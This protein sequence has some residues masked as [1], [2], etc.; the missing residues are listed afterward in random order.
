MNTPTLRAAIYARYSTDKQTESSI[1]DQIRVCTEWADREGLRTGEVFR[2]E[3]I[4]GAAIGNR[5]GYLTMMDAAKAGRFDALLVMDLSRLSR[6]QGDLPK[7]IERL[8]HSGVRVVGVQDGFDSARKGHKLQAGFSGIM[9]DWFRE[10]I[11]DK[12]YSALES[13]AKE[14]RR[15]G[16][17]SY[18]Y[19][20]TGSIDPAQAKVVRQ[21]FQMY[22]DGMSALAIANELNRRGVPSPGS[23]WKRKTRR[24]DKWL[25]SAINGD[26]RK[27]L[28]ILNNE[29]YRG[30]SIWNRSEWLRNPDTGKYKYRL[31]PL[32]EWIRWESPETRIVDDA[33][34]NRVRKRQRVQSQALGAAVKA[35]LANKHSGRGPK[36]L[37]SGLLKC[38]KCGAN[39]VVSDGRSYACSTYRNGGKA[40]CDHGVLVN[41]QLAESRLLAGV[42]DALLRPEVVQRVQREV[43]Q[44]LAERRRGAGKETAGL[45]AQLA[46]VDREVSNLVDRIADNATLRDSAAV[47]QRLADAEGRQQRLQQAL[48]EAEHP[49]AKVIEVIP[50]VAERY[51]ALVESFERHAYTRG[52]VDVAKARTAL[53]TL[54]GEVRVESEKESGRLVPVAVLQG[55]SRAFLRAAGAGM[56]AIDNCGSGGRI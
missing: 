30:I 22:A 21:I 48:A 54:L 27:G 2:D 42:K 4:S 6:N 19:T 25:A 53:R 1:K 39:F 31:R 23:T 15:T 47:A 37:L 14:H 56:P 33:L 51:R 55:N 28:G 8:V 50:R 13:R 41:R 9:G 17:R 52:P 26:P 20:T 34:W 46:K 11:A 44:V 18:G 16:G 29:R 24:K 7:T 5:P 10:M 32:T 40:A 49:A 12:T 35:G 36:W 45:R 38:G 3:G 43:R